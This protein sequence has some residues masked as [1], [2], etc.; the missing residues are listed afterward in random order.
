ME[1]LIRAPFTIFF[2]FLIIGLIRYYFLTNKTEVYYDGLDLFINM[3]YLIFRPSMPGNEY[4][5]WLFGACLAFCILSVICKPVRRLWEYRVY[6]YRR[7]KKTED[8]FQQN[9]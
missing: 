5:W 6:A 3:F 8:N 1:F 7:K 2:Y 4:F 9:R